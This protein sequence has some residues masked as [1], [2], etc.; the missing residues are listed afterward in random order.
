M[1]TLPIL[2]A[3]TPSISLSFVKDNNIAIVVDITIS[4][5]KPD[6]RLKRASSGAALLIAGAMVSAPKCAI[7]VIQTLQRVLSLYHL[8]LVSA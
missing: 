2:D 8:F 6:V 1:K 4:Q 5:K 7:P 3:P